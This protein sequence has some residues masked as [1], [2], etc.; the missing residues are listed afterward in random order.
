M[1]MRQKI[2]LKLNDIT[3]GIYKLYVDLIDMDGKITS[4]A[5]TKIKILP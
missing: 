5:N 3:P 2:Y 1:P 4:S